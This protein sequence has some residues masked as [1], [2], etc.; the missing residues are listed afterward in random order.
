MTDPFT[1]GDHR[2]GKA[3]PARISG[4]P[5]NEPDV[6]ITSDDNTCTL[7]NCRHLERVTTSAKNVGDHSELAVAGGVPLTDKVFKEVNTI[8]HGTVEQR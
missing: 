8:L 7:S 2:E 5:D 1:F 4:V 3:G 6:R